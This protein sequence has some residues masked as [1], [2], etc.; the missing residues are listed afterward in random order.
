MSNKKKETPKEIAWKVFLEDYN[1]DELSE[2]HERFLRNLESLKADHNKLVDPINKVMK[3]L[4]EIEALLLLTVRQGF[5][6]YETDTMISKMRE[7]EKNAEQ[8]T[9]KI[10]RLKAEIEKESALIKKYEE[11]SQNRLLG[12]FKYLKRFDPDLPEWVVFKEK[13]KK[14]I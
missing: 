10:H 12:H 3:E 5:F 8:M 6:S 14:I 2:R 1:D 4:S 7:L 11:N 9:E 13:W